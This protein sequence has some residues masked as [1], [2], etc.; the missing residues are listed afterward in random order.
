LFLPAIK[1]KANVLDTIIN[2]AIGLMVV[3]KAMIVLYKD[4]ATDSNEQILVLVLVVVV[5]VV[6]VLAGRVQSQGISSS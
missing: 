5:V 1:S 3:T 2:L 4:I 6:V